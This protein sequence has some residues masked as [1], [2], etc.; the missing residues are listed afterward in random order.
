MREGSLEMLSAQVHKSSQEA[1]S[2]NS[3]LASIPGTRIGSSK[4]EV[5][6]KYIS[7]ILADPGTRTV[8]RKIHF[9]NLGWSWHQNC[10][11][12]AEVWVLARQISLADD[13]RSLIGRDL[14][15]QLTF[16][17]TAA[18]SQKC[19]HCWLIVLIII[20]LIM[21]RM[22]IVLFAGRWTKTSLGRFDGSWFRLMQPF[23]FQLSV[24]FCFWQNSLII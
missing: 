9:K 18:F 24:L 20:W 21:F 14:N 15:T 23:Y 22:A 16:W 6:E 7:R 1:F 17:N 4:L 11:E 3:S 13:R 2:V 19:F 5:P 12:E 8:R 10:K